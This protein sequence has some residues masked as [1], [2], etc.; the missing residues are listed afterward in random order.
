M[1]QPTTDPVRCR[2]AAGPADL[3]AH[4]AVRRRVFVEEQGLFDGSD[5]D[6]RDDLPG[7]VHLVAELGGTVCGAVR[8]YPLAEDEARHF[9]L[10]GWRG[11]WPGT[12]WQ[13][14][15]LAVLPEFRRDNVGTPLVRLAVATAAAA[16]GG[17]MVARIQ[18]RN[19]RFFERLGWQVLGG[20]R[21][22]VG[23]LHQTMVIPLVPGR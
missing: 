16:G 3:A 7:T 1:A 5:R 13:G 9:D 19:V 4:L 23:L 22:Y 2:A 15:R 8:L 10:L 14:D 17:V 11:P 6:A 21:P 18:V 20:A 12:V